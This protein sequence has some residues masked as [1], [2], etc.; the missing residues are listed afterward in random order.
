MLSGGAQ[1][2]EGAKL[3][4]RC[5]DVRPGTCIMLRAPGR[6]E[7]ILHPTWINK[8]ETRILLQNGQD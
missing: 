5:W 8:D 1:D 2:A 7:A 4:G 6:R 3:P